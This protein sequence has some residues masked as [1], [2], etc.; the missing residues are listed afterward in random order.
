MLISPIISYN[1]PNTNFKGKLPSEKSIKNI[2]PKAQELCS[3]GCTVS[4]A[5]ITPLAMAC[6]NIKEFNNLRELPKEIED[7]GITRCTFKDGEVMIATNK[8]DAFYKIKL[9]RIPL[10]TTLK[11]ILSE[12]LNGGETSFIKGFKN[13]KDCVDNLGRQDIVRKGLG[14]RTYELD[15][16]VPKETKQFAANLIARHSKIATSPNDLFFIDNNAYYYDKINKTAYIVNSLENIPQKGKKDVYECKFITD[17]NGHAIGYDRDSFS[18]YYQSKIKDKYMEQTEPSESLPDYVDVNK[19]KLFAEACRFG[20]YRIS[21]RTKEGI[22]FVLSKLKELGF[23]NV[24]EA[25][26]Q[27]VRG[28]NKDKNFCLINYYNPL[29]GKSL[30]FNAEGEFIFQTEYEKNEN[31]QILFCHHQQRL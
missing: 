22:P 3:T 15:N 27:I 24:T 5:L 18:I 21:S 30:T 23:K 28:M 1:S 29:S 25:D 9:P 12:E 16:D 11:D 6:N 8:N 13:Y 2:M 31:G 7:A 4:T 26:L 17:S 10:D 20:N 19:N 14:I